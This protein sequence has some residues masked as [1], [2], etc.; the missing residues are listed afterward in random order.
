VIPLADLATISLFHEGIEVG[1]IA[2]K[3]DGKIPNSFSVSVV[4]YR[5]AHQSTRSLIL[6]E[7][8]KAGFK[9]EG[10]ERAWDSRIL[11]F[12]FSTPAPAPED[13]DTYVEDSPVPPELA[14]KLASLRTALTEKGFQVEN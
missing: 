6:E 11:P 13:W 5:E 7:V 12:L 4:T 10:F 2:V 14:E 1:H 8:R 9:E 3:D